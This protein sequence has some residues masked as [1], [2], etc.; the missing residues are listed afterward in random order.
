MVRR[1]TQH[2]LYEAMQRCHPDMPCVR[3]CLAKHCRVHNTDHKRFVFYMHLLDF[4]ISL[5]PVRP[6]QGADHVMCRA[7]HPWQAAAS[8]EWMDAG[9]FNLRDAHAAGWPLALWQ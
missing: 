5:P 9:Y 2:G 6:E 1:S 3:R 4:G 7:V 8:H